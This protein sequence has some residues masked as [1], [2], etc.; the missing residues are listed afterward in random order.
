MMREPG[1]IARRT[2]EL[3]SPG[4]EHEDGRSVYGSNAC[5]RSELICLVDKVS[6]RPVDWWTKLSIVELLPKMARR[7]AE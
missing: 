6:E 1:F 3:E 7:K 5:C 4:N 2:S